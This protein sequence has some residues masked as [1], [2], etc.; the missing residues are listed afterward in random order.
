MINALVCESIPHGS[1]LV[2]YRSIPFF[3]SLI[4]EVSVVGDKSPITLIDTEK[5][6]V[7]AQLVL[8]PGYISLT[9]KSSHL[10]GES[11]PSVADSMYRRESFGSA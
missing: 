8:S 7:K 5:G 3:T 6:E 1:S 10:G 2:L 9:S 11:G 4:H